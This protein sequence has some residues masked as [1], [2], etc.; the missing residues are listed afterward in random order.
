MLPPNWLLENPFRSLRLSA[1]A[2]SADAHK[3]ASAMRRMAVLTAATLTE[4]G[5]PALGPLTRTETSIR[6]SLGRIESP[7]L[8]IFDRLFWFHQT[9]SEDITPSDDDLRA[10][11]RQAASRHDDALH[12]LLRLYQTDPIPEDPESWSNAFRAW[13]IEFIFGISHFIRTK[14]LFDS[15]RRPFVGITQ[16]GSILSSC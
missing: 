13:H 3:A 2:T 1:N 6:A 15:P 11:L 5:F 4:S 16:L 9:P 7:A 8:R 12:A 10:P 14:D